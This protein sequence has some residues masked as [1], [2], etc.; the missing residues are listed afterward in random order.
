MGSNSH[1]LLCAVNEAPVFTKVP[2]SQEVLDGETVTLKCTAQGKPIPQIMWL[3]G[4]Q[5]ME[6]D[7][8]VTIVTEADE[9]KN[10]VNSTLSIKKVLLDDESEDYKIEA[11]NSIGQDQ[12]QFALKCNF[13]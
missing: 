2:D 8:D 1:P 6:P 9:S 4:E 12:A 5:V 10:K 7:D 3:K 11:T 13:V